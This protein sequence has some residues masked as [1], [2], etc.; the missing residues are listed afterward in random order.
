MLY[1]RGDGSDTVFAVNAAPIYDAS[2][3]ITVVVSTF[4]DISDRKRAE[5]R[6]RESALRDPLTGLAN[7]TLLRDRLDQAL[8]RARRARLPAAL[9]LVD[10]DRFKDVN[11][12]LGHAAGDALLC[13]VAERLSDCVRASDT[14]ARLGGDEFAL[15]LDGLQVTVDAE[16]VARKA[17][18]AMAEPFVLDG[19]EVRIGASVGIALG[20]CDG[21]TPDRMLRRA[22]LA[23]YRVKTSGRGGHAFY[24]PEMA[25]RVEA[26]ASLER[27]LRRAIERGD[28]F[29]LV[30][31]PEIDL[32]SGVIR[33]AEALLRWRHPERG[34]LLP[35]EFIP[36]AEQSRLIVPLGE[37]VVH[38]A[39]RQARAWR[40]R[41][42][43]ELVIAVNVSL[44][45]F[46]RG[47]DFAAVAAA[48]LERSGLSPHCLELEVTESLFASEDD[49]ASLLTLKDLRSR[50]VSIS[51]DDFG[52]GYSNLGQL[53]RLPVDKVK[54]DRSFMVGLGIDPDAEA[55][56]RAAVALAH[57]LSLRTTAEGVETEEQLALIRAIGCDG[58]QGFLLGGPISAD[59]FG[60]LLLRGDPWPAARAAVAG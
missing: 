3:R 7:R 51:V 12:T 25:A 8:A 9:L 13:E 52:T 15:L 30:Y 58:V 22:D 48:A 53:R 11:D 35:D 36:V 29:E 57:A 1:R 47:A 10:L 26:R 16:T 37:W 54:V 59:A 40:D 46:Q 17:V 39:C 21:D 4:H 27:D 42:L 19:E 24:D 20:P 33:G 28:E 31:Q 45:Q 32:A 5:E 18:A 38:E 34:W 43:P 2:G 55:L 50:G 49:R 41:G 14:A 6:V 60:V 56:V 23:L 44:A